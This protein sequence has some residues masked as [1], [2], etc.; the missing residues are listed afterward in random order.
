MQYVSTPRNRQIA[1]TVKEMGWIEHYGTG[2]RRVRKMFLDYGLAEPKYETLS[3]GMA[4]TVF[5]LK[6]ET[7]TEDSTNVGVQVEVQVGV[8]VE[9]L[10]V[11]IDDNFF[12]TKDA[13]KQLNLKQRH[14]VFT[15]YIQPALKLGLIEMTIPDKPNSRLQKYCLTQKGKDAKEKLI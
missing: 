1:K 2:I 14:K 11:C 5:G 15:N 9:K 3:G 4:V 7:D 12:T 8:Q 10:L 6:F 13:Q